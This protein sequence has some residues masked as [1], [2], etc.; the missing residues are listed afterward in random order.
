MAN[1]TKNLKRIGQIAGGVALLG[2]GMIAYLAH[3][4]T[5]ESYREGE[6]TCPFLA[7]NPPDTS[8]LLT[9]AAG[10]EDNGMSYPMALFVGFDV[11]RKQRG[12]WAAITLR[13][14]DLHRLRE[15]DGVSHD[16]RFALFL[17]ELRPLADERAID[18]RIT[19]QDLVELKHWVAKRTGVE[20]I[21]EPSRIETSLA[22]IRAGGDLENWTVTVDDLFAL[23][24]GKRPSADAIVTIESLDRARAH[25]EWNAP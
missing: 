25:A 21:S 23:L 15:V 12:L 8:N 7:L 10:A 14:P 22:F 13:A 16:D 6:V 24:S 2:V 20:T 18:G 19:L 3:Q 9:F 17:D 11:T 5:V 1:G 4:T